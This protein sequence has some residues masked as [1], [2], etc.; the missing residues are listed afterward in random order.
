MDRV[1]KADLFKG[2]EDG[3]YNEII[4]C[5]ISKRL[6]SHNFLFHQGDAATQC[7]MVIK[8]QLRLTKLNE[9]GK[10]VT[11]RYVGKGELTAAVA[12]LKNGSYPVTAESIRETTV[13]G[14][15]HSTIMALMRRFPEVAINL[16]GI[17]LARIEDVQQR[18][19]EICT[20]Q[21]DQ[22]VAR[23]LL[24]LMRWKGIT[25]EKGILI[26]I[27]LSR[28]SLADYSGTTLFTVSRTLSAWEKMGWV[29]TGRER[30]IVTDPHALVAFAE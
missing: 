27:P 3:Q 29:E 26:D 24:R 13:V 23:S 30:I 16:L 12:V 4:N 5:A 1:T 25:H 11:I 20:E 28:Q 19:L 18:Y 15:D 8:G 22:R 2:L 21:V 7:Y 6:P 10:M 9:N 17:V 14:W